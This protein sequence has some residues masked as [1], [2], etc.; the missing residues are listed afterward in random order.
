MRSANYDLKDFCTWVVIEK[1]MHINQTDAVFFKYN[2]VSED[3]IYAIIKTW[4]M[5]HKLCMTIYIYIY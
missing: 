5:T 3:V 1:L 2:T 4:F